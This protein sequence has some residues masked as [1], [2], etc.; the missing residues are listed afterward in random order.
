M[1]KRSDLTGQRFG[2]L[3]TK[4]PTRLGNRTAWSCICDCGNSII[5]ATHRL[6]SETTKS[7]GCLRKDVV[8][9]LAVQRNTVHGHNIVGSRTGTHKSWSA[10]MSRCNCTSDGSYGD[11]G[12]R[13][14]KVCERWHEY[15]NFL[16]D[17]GERPND[18]S[19]DRIDVD[20]D[21]CPENCRWAT[22][23]EQQR[24]RR[25]HK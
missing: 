15:V 1:T 16:E 12:G 20:G 14:I 19:I 3:V 22:R 11:Y 8:S 4:C 9:F 7:C 6:S 10:M 23:S 21:Y 24:N 17:M 2:R 5:V 25:C 18:R 13:G